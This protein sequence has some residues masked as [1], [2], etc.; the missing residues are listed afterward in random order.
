MK[1]LGTMLRR[2]EVALFVWVLGTYAYFFQ[3]GGWNANVRFALVRSVVEQG[4]LTID[5]YRYVSGDLA[6][7]AGHFYC[8]KAPGVSAL[9]VPIYAAS[10]LVASETPPSRTEQH[11][12]LY[13]ATLAVIGVP[14]AVAVVLL[15]HLARHLSP[16]PLPRLIL[17]L[18]YGLGTAAFPYATLYYGHQLLGAL[19]VTAF[20]LLFEV[21][22]DRT[23]QTP[24]RLALVG[25]L[26][27]LGVAVEYT[28]AIA[29][30]ALLAYAATVV[31]SWRRRGVLALGL[32]PPAFA[33]ALYHTAAF[34][35]PLT[36]A[37]HFSTQGNRRGGFFMGIAAIDWHAL[38]AILLSEQRGL[39]YSAPWLLLAIPG[40]VALWR[41]GFRS[42]VT[43]CAFVF[44]AYAWMN[45]SL[46]DWQGGWTFGARY[47]VPALP[48]LSVLAM[49]LLPWAA[50]GYQ[51]DAWQRRLRTLGTTA[52]LLLVGYSMAM[53]LV[54]T[55]VW[56][57]IDIYYKRPFAHFLLR[58][59]GEGRLALNAIPVDAR[60]A[61]A[62]VGPQAWNVGQLLGLGGLASLLPL[63]A[64][65]LLG[66]AWTISG[67]RSRSRE[68]ERAVG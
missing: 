49:G 38:H 1:H 54:A 56:P 17:A 34:G 52:V 21:R 11:V 20:V 59:F 3:A 36:I 45:A 46:V 39:F 48:F 5:D 22:M 16:A 13:L 26:L 62:G 7:R 29:V 68:P 41:R 44:S 51:G 47:L 31:R 15:F 42:E 63:A 64:W 14:S 66:A 23:W 57:E 43:T 53:M 9:S 37:Y 33:L 4:R 8:D 2:P 60:R 67:T 27:G 19:A 28:A 55:S 65:Q 25:L 30:V 58:A 24:G 10:R 6:K 40:A 50:S 35:F 61:L 32:L 18:A 12:A